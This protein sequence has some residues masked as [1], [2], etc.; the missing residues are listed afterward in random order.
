MS[1]IRTIIVDD[2][3]ALVS[4]LTQFLEQDGRCAIVG[5][6]D[7]GEGGV[8]LANETFPDLVIMDVSLPDIGGIEAVQRI[9]K[10]EDGPKVIVLTM[11]S[12]PAFREAAEAAGADG[13]C[14]KA[15]AQRELLRMIEDLFPDATS[16]E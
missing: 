14:H 13:F 10:S 9:K 16:G 5:T 6:S 2:S 8:R 4:S 11:H 7:S 15:S 12:H 3:P 1:H